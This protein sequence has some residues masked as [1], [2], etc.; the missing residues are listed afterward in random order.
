MH[1][2]CINQYRSVVDEERK[3]FNS[4]LKECFLELKEIIIIYRNNITIEK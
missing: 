3:K 2:E 4:I 1:R